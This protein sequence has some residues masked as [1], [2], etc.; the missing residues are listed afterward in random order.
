MM[1]DDWC[2]DDAGRG[3]I[4]GVGKMRVSAARSVYISSDEG[5]GMKVSSDVGVSSVSIEC[6]PVGW[7]FLPWSIPYCCFSMMEPCTLHE[8]WSRLPS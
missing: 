6:R 8:S 4:L 1:N 7:T 3:C 2:V 5:L